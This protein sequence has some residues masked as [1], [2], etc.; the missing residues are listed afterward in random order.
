MPQAMAGK[1]KPRF[2]GPYL[3]VELI[4]EVAVC[5]ALPPQVRLHDVFHVGLLKKFQG[6]PPQ[7][8]PA[9]PPVRHGAIVPEPEQAVKSRLVRGMR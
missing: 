3:M 7:E 6:T 2:Y 5:L 8:P 1:L 9:L 4:N